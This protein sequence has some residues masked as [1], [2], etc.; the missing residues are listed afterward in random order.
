[1]SKR[2][3]SRVVS[4]VLLAGLGAALWWALKNQPQGS[5]ELRAALGLPPELTPQERATQ[6]ANAAAVARSEE[7]AR[8]VGSD[9]YDEIAEHWGRE[10]VAY[11]NAAVDA[12]RAVFGNRGGLAGTGVYQTTQTTR[13]DLQ[14]LAGLECRRAVDD[15]G[16]P[17]AQLG[18]C[19]A[20]VAQPRSVPVSDRTH[21]WT[22]PGGRQVMWVRL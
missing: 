7:L 8:K 22:L 5:P 6:R 4:L 21:E 16:M 12:D 3:R 9:A 2:P 11:V 19:V 13:D 20:K 18:A 15:F 14:V 1:M 17:A 10:G